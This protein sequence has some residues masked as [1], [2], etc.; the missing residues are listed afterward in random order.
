MKL[1]KIIALLLSIVTIVTCGSVYAEN[2]ADAQAADTEEQYYS[3]E[4]NAFKQMAEYISQLYIDDSISKE[5]IMNQGISKLLELR[6]SEVA[7]KL[8]IDSK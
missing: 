6:S 1:K 7:E 4:F 3:G 2:V 8:G 5:E